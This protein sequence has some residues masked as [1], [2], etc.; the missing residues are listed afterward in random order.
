[1]DICENTGLYKHECQCLDCVPWIWRFKE[2][3]TDCET[4][5]DVVERLEDTLA[6]FSALNDGDYSITGD[7]AHDFMELRPPTRQGFY[8]MRCDDCGSLFEVPRGSI[9]L[10]CGICRSDTLSKGE[11]HY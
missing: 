10:N 11:M 5:S 8:W 6:Y 4:V 9:S 3:C 1:M 7:I 2:L